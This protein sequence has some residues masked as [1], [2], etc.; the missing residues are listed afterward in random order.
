[1]RSTSVPSLTRCG[2]A[3]AEIRLAIR[4][5]DRLVL[6]TADRG[7]GEVPPLREEHGGREHDERDADVAK[8]PP[9]GHEPARRA[10]EGET[11]PVQRVGLGLAV[12]L[13]RAV[14]LGVAVAGGAVAVGSWPDLNFLISVTMSPSSRRFS[15]K[16][17]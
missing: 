17:I 4:E 3:T 12:A 10:A 7:N 13:G 2:I 8:T 9:V 14:G 11:E 15:M 5:E 16:R 6:R 1:M